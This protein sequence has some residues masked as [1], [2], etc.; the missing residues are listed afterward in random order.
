MDNQRKATIFDFQRMCKSFKSCGECALRGY[1]DCNFSQMTPE[2]ISR[3]NDLILDWCEDHPIKS[4]TLQSAYLKLFPN[5]KLIRGV[6]DRCPAAFDCRF[7][8]DANIDCTDCKR[9]FWSQLIQE[10]KE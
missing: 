7:I 1:N 3:K 8:C 10:E 4:T 9:A 5:T 2:E 6:I